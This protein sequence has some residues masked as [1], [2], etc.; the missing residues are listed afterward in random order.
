MATV[1]T[2]DFLPEIFQTSTNKQ[3]L[4]ATLDQLVQE[5]QFKKTQGYIGRRVGPGV[6]ADDRYVVE[7][8]RSRTDYQLEPGV[9][10]RKTDSTVINDAVT[11][12]GITDALGTQGA[13]V[14]ES[15]RLYTSEYYTWDP[16]INWDM[17][18]NYSQYHWLPSGPLSV[19]VGGTAVPLTADYTV[20][21]ENGVYTFSDY[22]G[23]NPTITLLRNGNYTFTVAQ[24]A[25]ETVNYRVTAATT[26]AYIIDYL[27][28]PALTLVRGNTYVFNL[29]LDVVSPFWIKTSP[30]QGR[31]DQYNTGVS[32]NG[33]NTGNITFTVPQDAPN[34]LY[35]ASETQFN[36]Q[37]TLT[38]VDGTPG[39]GPGFWIQAEPGVA[40]VLPWSPN[41]SSRDVLGVTNNGED[42]GVVEFDVPASTAPDQ[43]WPC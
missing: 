16:Q 2:V 20:T 34:T 39:T 6:N 23:S 5:P 26:S 13:F 7:P 27:P 4:A 9:I 37:G 25:T 38:I 14:D 30:S 33:A 32:R 11:Y 17:F 36:M 21:R 42:L 8:T 31:T 10:F 1:R 35:Y 22:T 28:N 41:I 19:D 12:P 15:E 3:F 43:Y 40:G 24:N 29:N 18:V